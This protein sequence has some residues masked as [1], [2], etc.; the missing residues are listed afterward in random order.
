M[1]P[2]LD[3]TNKTTFF[4]DP[5]GLQGN[6]QCCTGTIFFSKYCSGILNENFTL[7]VTTRVWIFDGIVVSDTIWVYILFKKLHS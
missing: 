2:I 5:C 7:F 6:Y 4:G 3:T 1:T